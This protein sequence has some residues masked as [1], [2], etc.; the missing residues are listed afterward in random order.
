MQLQKTYHPKASELTRKWHLFDANGKVLGR[1]SSE[2]SQILQGK[3]KAYYTKGADC[4]D[5]VIVINA[6][7]VRTTGK[8]AEQ[9]I[10]FRYTGHTGGD[11]YKSYKEILASK[12]EDI[13]ISAVSGMLP[14]NKMRAVMLKR[15]KIYA[16]DTHPHA[17]QI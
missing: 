15:L 13:I 3:H 10:Y 6:S 11:K 1:M 4:G 9:L 7:K 2:I 12:P 5:F 14:K 17:A 8:K 16:G